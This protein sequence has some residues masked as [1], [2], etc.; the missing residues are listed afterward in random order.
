[1][2]LRSFVAGAGLVAAASALLLPPDLSIIDDSDDAITTLP[3]ST[4]IDADVTVAN[5]PQSQTLDLACPGCLQFG[6]KHRKE[7]PSHLKLDFTIESTDGVDRLTLNGYELYP[8]PIPL[9]DTLTAPVLPN[10]A[11]RRMGVPPRFRGGPGRAWK[12]QPLGFAM[13]TGVVAIDDDEDLRLINVELQ[14][15]EVGNIFVEH[16][17]NV[18]VQLV[19]TPSGKLAIGAIETIGFRDEDAG[20]KQKECSTMVCKWK[21]VFFEKLSHIFK[22]CGG[23]KGH[24]QPPHHHGEHGQGHG[25][26]P[27]HMGHKPSWGHGLKIFVRHILFPILIGIV[28]GISASIIGMIFGT[29]VVFLWRTFVRRRG[30]R[31]SH[32]CRYAHKA[33]SH[34]RAADEEKSGLLDVQEETEAPPGYLDSTTVVA[35]EKKPENEA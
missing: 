23:Q 1:M 19:K 22:S 24:P 3:V 17:P 5:A 18:Q 20:G 2:H 30:S 13:Q 27:H 4:E 21:A 11:D 25:P 33:T 7:V 29:F 6:R 8:N 10:M 16:I 34:E 12:N 32:R 15:V 9:Q 14:I 26:H 28:A 31:S 35:E